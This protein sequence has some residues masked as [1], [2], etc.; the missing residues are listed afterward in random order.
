MLWPELQPKASQVLQNFNSLIIEFLV[1][2]TIEVAPS[3]SHFIIIS[4]NYSLINDGSFTCTFWVQRLTVIKVTKHQMLIRF[5]NREITNMQIKSGS[6][7]LQFNHSR[8]LIDGLLN[9][10]S[11][12]LCTFL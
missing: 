7:S 10:L 4:F 2:R 5:W 9:L 1:V 11:T 8:K 12:L 6:V 3:T